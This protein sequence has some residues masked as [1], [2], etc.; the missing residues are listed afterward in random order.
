[1]RPVRAPARALAEL[2]DAA[3]MV[4]VSHGRAEAFAELY[5]RYGARSYRLAMLVC[6]DDGQAEDTV[7]EA[8]VSIWR[9]RASYRPEAGAVSTWVLSIVRYR[10]IDLRRRNAGHAEHRAGERLLVAQPAAVDVAA[11]AAA[12]VDAPALRA[13]LARLPPTQRE[14]IVLAFFGGLTHLEIATRLG[15]PSGTVKGRMRLGLQKLRGQ[16]TRAA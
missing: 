14:V 2:D 1:M 10:A 5:Q 6:R 12:R 15:L 9:S 13:V 4:E 8:F 11:E 16:V 3:L 7:Q